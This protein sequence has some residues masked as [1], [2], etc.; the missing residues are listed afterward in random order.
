[1][2]KPGSMKGLEELGRVRL[3]PSF[4]M[5]DMLYSEIS[6]FYGIPNIPENPDRAIESGK[7]LC[8]N[9]L[10]PLQQKFGR[11]SIRSAYR[12]PQLNKF[13][14]ENKLNCASNKNNYARHIWD[15]PDENG[16]GALA[17][18]VVNAYADY[19]A[20]TGDWQSLAWYI[21]DR[22]P[23]STLYFYPKLCA[24]NIGW[25][26]HPERWIKSFITPKGTLT[27]M[28]MEN[29]EGP[30]TAKYDTMLKALAVD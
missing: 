20:A 1:M 12:S 29:H 13:G 7:Q 23:Y 14:N 26:E 10:E 18:I 22:L 4:F 21:H 27:K 17:T 30:H 5:R 25:H 28:S 11:I 6:N 9:L 15:M 19:Y 3:S 2:R 24:F 8:E 16:Y